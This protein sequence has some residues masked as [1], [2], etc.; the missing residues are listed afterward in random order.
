MQDNAVAVLGR[1]LPE[2]A[3]RCQRHNIPHCG[4][5]TDFD[6]RF[7]QDS[8][9]RRQRDSQTFTA[10][11]K[12]WASA[13]T[14]PWRSLY[15]PHIRG[16][17]FSRHFKPD[18]SPSK[19]TANRVVL[20]YQ[21]WELPVANTQ[22]LKDVSM[23]VLKDLAKVFPQRLSFSS[24]WISINHLH[25]H[26]EIY[27]HKFSALI[28]SLRRDTNT[29]HR[30]CS[31]NTTRSKWYVRNG[32]PHSA[33]AGPDQVSWGLFAKKH[34]GQGVQRIIFPRPPWTRQRNLFTIIWLLSFFGGDNVLSI[35]ENG[36]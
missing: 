26:S 9:S 23:K 33:S 19:V 36:Q 17:S 10:A 14:F 11:L 27:S 2:V 29:N 1:P 30:K 8:S 32:W 22:Q 35:S 4:T 15:L 6:R 24:T 12:Q 34:V 13:A 28:E 3:R 20:S 16:V 25:K 5:F 21:G 18:P 31:I 7:G